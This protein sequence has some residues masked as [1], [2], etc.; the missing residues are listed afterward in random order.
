MTATAQEIINAANNELGLPAVAF[1]ST[2]GDTLSVQSLALLNAL[3]QELV[4]AHDWQFL[5]KTMN[6]IGDGVVDV[7]DLP[8]DFGRQVNQ[9]Q[10]STK[11]QRPMMGPDSPQV[12]AWSQ[13]GIVSVGVWF[14]YR[15]VGNQYTLFPVPGSGEEFALYY[16]SKNWVQDPTLPNSFKPLVTKSSDVPLFDE[17]LLIAGLKLK[18]WAQKGFETTVLQGEFNYM[19]NNFK[20]QTQGAPVIDLAGRSGQLFISWQNT[21]DTGFG[22]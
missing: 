5:E 13:Y 1:N 19:L 6:F 4:R 18:L 16:I 21:P 14:R 3:G 11:D 10:W 22:V 20:A 12:W 2:T 7:W 15:I 8:S 17:R 9:T